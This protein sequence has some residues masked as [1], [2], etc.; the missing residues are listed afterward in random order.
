MNAHAQSS[1]HTQWFDP[2][3]E[4]DIRARVEQVK[5]ELAPHVV[6]RDRKGSA[7]LRKHRFFG[8]PVWLH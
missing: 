1:R 5:T 8:S 2:P 7:P 6:G 4:A 3:I